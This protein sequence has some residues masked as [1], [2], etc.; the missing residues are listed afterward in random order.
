M[1]SITFGGDN[2]SVRRA[3]VQGQSFNIGDTVVCQGRECAV[4]SR[5]GDGPRPSPDCLTVRY[6]PAKLTPDMIEADLS[7]L[8]LGAAGGATIAAAFLPRMG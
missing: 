2:G 7:G 4:S 5:E 6:P 1:I 3:E 8:G